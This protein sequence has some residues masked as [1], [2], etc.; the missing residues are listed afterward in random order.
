[1]MG[2]SMRQSTAATVAAS[3]FELLRGSTCAAIVA[4]TATTR[5]ITESWKVKQISTNMFDVTDSVSFVP[6]S[7]RAP[8]KQSYRSY[9]KC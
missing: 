8:V 4:G 9:V 2:G 5:G 6:M 3:R 1:M 7:R